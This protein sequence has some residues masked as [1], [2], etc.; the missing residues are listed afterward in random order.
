MSTPTTGTVPLAPLIQAFFGN[1]LIAQ[2]DLSRKT[3]ASYRDTFRLLLRF[4]ERDYGHAP[5][6]LTLSDLSTEM[7]L[8][9][10]DHLDNERGNSVRT[11]NARL[12]A[13]RSLFQYVAFEVPQQLNLVHPI[14]AIPMKRFDRP[15]VRYLSKPEIDTVVTSMNLQTWTGRRDHAMLSTLYNT[16]ARVSEL[17]AIRVRDVN[18]SPSSSWLS[19]HGKGRKDRSVPLWKSTGQLLKNWIR[20]LPS[21]LDQPLFPRSDGTSLSRSAVELRLKR[22]V[23][24]G[25]RTCPSLRN[26]TIS[27]HVIRH[28]TA[29]HLL[30]AGVDLSVIALWLGHESI[31]TT[32]QYLEADLKTKAEA[33]SRVE[34]SPHT[35]ARY[36]PQDA[37]LRFLESL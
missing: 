20:E 28:T 24:V 14:L 13:I 5:A 22:A 1:R 17:T 32:H 3:V 25:A 26:K 18:L 16:G 29:M 36:R 19:L 31:Q 15:P 2:R 21:E 12:A 27:P 33:M 35:S 9:F 10:L 7:T 4:V 11:R 30:N 37:L 8:S 6:S 34:P 23:L